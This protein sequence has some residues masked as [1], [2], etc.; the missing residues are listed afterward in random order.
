[1]NKYNKRLYRLESIGAENIFRRTEYFAIDKFYF[2]SMDSEFE[3]FPS[4]TD[5]CF[6]VC[7]CQLF[8]RF[9]KDVFICVWYNLI[10]HLD[11]MVVY[12]K[13][14]HVPNAQKHNSGRVPIFI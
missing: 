14:K 6:I 13:H 12:R 2:M 8:V 11:N 4:Q 10:I 3:S 9:K 5:L 1:M 7:I